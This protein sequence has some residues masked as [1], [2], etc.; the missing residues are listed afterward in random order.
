MKGSLEGIESRLEHLTYLVEEQGKAIN[1]LLAHSSDLSSFLMVL[2][3]RVGRV[4]ASTPPPTVPTAPSPRHLR[5][6]RRV[7][8]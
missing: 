7:G 6:R 1:A 3:Q 8:R 4:E 2:Q 5:T